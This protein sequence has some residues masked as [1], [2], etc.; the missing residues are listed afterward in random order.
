MAGL[1]GVAVGW[2]CVRLGWVGY[3]ETYYARGN[4][5]LR[6]LSDLWTLISRPGN[7]YQFQPTTY[8]SHA[9]DYAVFGD[10]VAAFHGVNVALYAL[11]CALVAWLTQTLWASWG[12]NKGA[13]EAGFLA[14]LLFAV[15]P[16]HVESYAWLGDRK[17]LLA[18]AL[19]IA[20]YLA[21][22]HLPQAGSPRR[23]LGLHLL[24]GGL[25]A[26]A[27]GAKLSAAPLGACLALEGL[28]REGGGLR[29]RVRAA[30]RWGGPALVLGALLSVGWYALQLR[31][32]VPLGRVS[33]QGPLERGL[34]VLRSYGHYVRLVL[35]P[36]E[37]AVHYY[38]RPA[39]AEW[40][41]N[42]GWG[43]AGILGGWALARD[44]GLRPLALWAGG[45]FV[46]GL[47]LVANV[48]PLGYV[49][50]RYLLLPSVG[51]AA[52]LGA[53]ATRGGRGRRAALLAAAAAGVALSG[54][55]IPTWSSSERLWRQVLE[56]DPRHPFA[57]AQVARLEAAAGN[58]ER[59]E[60]LVAEARDE[61]PDAD[62]PA[63][64]TAEL[65]DRRGERAAASALLRAQA[66]RSQEVTV[67]LHLGQRALAAGE[68]PRAQTHALRAL[69]RQPRSLEALQL[70]AGS[71]LRLGDAELALMFCQRGLEVAAPPELALLALQSALSA[72]RWELAAS[73]LTLAERG[74]RTWETD[75][76]AAQ[77]AF[78]RG[79]PQEL[80][81]RLDAC[82]AT[83]PREL[84]PAIRQLVGLLERVGR[85][86]QALAVLRE[87]R[88]PPP[89]LRLL[90]AHFEVRL[91][92][93][94][95]A[96]V[97]LRRALEAAPGLRE[98]ARQDPLLRPWTEE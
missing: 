46:L 8:A 6:D 88:Q 90:R 4:L 94:L 82:V 78:E 27:L 40:A 59:A 47:V 74:G 62:F 15:H 39:F 43:L 5:Y 70:A 56:V 86:E 77:L 24:G 30:W 54:A 89:D 52:L 36:S 38:P 7:G 31:Y 3:D 57:L 76:L 23:R 48:I 63:L 95:A 87:V 20:S 49:N 32:P 68:I 12:A 33:A 2:P 10:S 84:H 69:A 98:R 41:V 44:R 53:W 58:L 96:R 17:D 13:A 97:Q 51:I 66:A 1:A 14:G 22:R 64:V 16:V 25:L 67:E 80:L 45:W 55:Q 71:T 28:L 18:C 21:Y 85:G 26:L 42:L 60:Q 92:D 29:A 79:R 81:A 93:P 9:L 75:L 65:L 73:Y 37:L 50:D 72:G 83:V 34:F 19:G 61:D 35:W 11:C 91:G